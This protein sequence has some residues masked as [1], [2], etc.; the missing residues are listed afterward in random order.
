M[1]VSLVDGLQELPLMF[2][3]SGVVDLLLQFGVFVDE[4]SLTQYVGCR[5][6]Y[7]H[8]NNPSMALATGSPWKPST[9]TGLTPPP[10]PQPPS[11]AIS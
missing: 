8:T 6:L 5:V 10:T 7:L 4:P 1:C 11:P 3:D 2:A 9:A